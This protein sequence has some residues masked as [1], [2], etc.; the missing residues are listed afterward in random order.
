MLEVVNAKC[1]AHALLYNYYLTTP[2]SM[3]LVDA[4]T[5]LSRDIEGC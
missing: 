2:L 3:T 5:H 1:E 4:R